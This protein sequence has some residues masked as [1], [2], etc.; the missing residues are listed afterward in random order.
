MNILEH[1]VTEIKSI[2][3]KSPTIGEMTIPCVIVD[4]TQNCY[5]YIKKGK[6]ALSPEQYE[7]VVENGYYMG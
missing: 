5:G 4:C 6:V 2:E 3:F 1:Y 7:S